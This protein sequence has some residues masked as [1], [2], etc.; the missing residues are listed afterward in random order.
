MS[1]E[2]NVTQSQSESFL[3]FTVGGQLY[4]VDIHSVV[5]I[6]GY[7]STT[8]LP[9]ML[10]F[11]LGVINIRGVVI[12][13]FDLQARFGGQNS[14]LDSKKVIIIVSVEGQQLGFL[15]DAV[16]GIIEEDSANIKN[17]SVAQTAISED[18]MKGI[19]SID[20]SMV[21]VL[22]INSIVAVDDLNKI[23]H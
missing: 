18:F 10:D 5:E 9:H 23:K 7:T 2:K 4:C 1:S 6:K 20:D 13:I 15:V 11:M 14:E 8:K 22:N 21:I 17:S 12:P 3:S 19:I 16:N